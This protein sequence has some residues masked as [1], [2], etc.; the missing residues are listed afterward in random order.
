MT[1]SRYFL[2]DKKVQFLQFEALN[3]KAWNWQTAKCCRY[4]HVHCILLMC[5]TIVIL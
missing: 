3:F 4:L 2:C 1:Y 5:W